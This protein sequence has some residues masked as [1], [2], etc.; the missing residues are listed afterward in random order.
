MIRAFSKRTIILACVLS[1][2]L[3]NMSGWPIHRGLVDVLVPCL[4]SQ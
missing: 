2:L 4:G 1:Q 3:A